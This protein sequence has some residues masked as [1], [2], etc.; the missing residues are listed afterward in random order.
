VAQHAG[1][2]AA[3]QLQHPSRHR[4]AARPGTLRQHRHQLLHQPAGG[5]PCALVLVPTCH[6]TRYSEPQLPAELLHPSR[7]HRRTRLRPHFS[8]AVGPALN[9]NVD[10]FFSQGIF[11]PNWRKITPFTGAPALF[12]FAPPADYSRRRQ[13]FSKNRPLKPFCGR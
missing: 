10:S 7:R 8:A 3:L 2:L 1:A 9:K 5:H 6:A 4:A 11:P 12:S 13:P